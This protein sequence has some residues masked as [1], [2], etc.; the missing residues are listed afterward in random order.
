MLKPTIPRVQ[1]LLAF[2]GITPA[3]GHPE[4]DQPV[5]VADRDPAALPI[6]RNLGHVETPAEGLHRIGDD[7]AKITMESEFL[8]DRSSCSLTI[9]PS[10]NQSEAKRV[11]Q[12]TVD[13][14]HLWQQQ[15]QKS[16]ST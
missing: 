6:L 9:H 8:L 10:L 5:L 2:V 7:R 11:V 12:S 15:T 14:L 16:N 13:R 3:A 4:I 1:N